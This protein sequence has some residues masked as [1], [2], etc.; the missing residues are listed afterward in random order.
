MQHALAIRRGRVAAALQWRPE[1]PVTLVVGVAWVA[2]AV[3]AAI[4]GH[5]HAGAA[6]ALGAWTLMAVAMMGPMAL[7]AV[8]H[9]AL[10]SLRAR[11]ARAMALYVA[12]FM[13]VWVAFGIAALGADAVATGTLA[14][15]GQILLAATL[16]IAAAWQLTPAK[17]RAIYACTRTV[18]L[19]PSGRKADRGVARFA[20]LQ[21]RR[22]VRS[23]WALMLVMVAAGHTNLAWMAG[24]TAFILFEEFTLIGR[25]ALWPAASGLAFAAAVVALGAA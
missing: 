6:A 9:V 10:N 17:R 4:N 23:C 2:C 21:A 1:W 18:A 24:L 7:P 5:D 12:V 20:R 13:A 22:S 8:R 14:I 16:A 15:D 19:P 3:L 25:D 11:R